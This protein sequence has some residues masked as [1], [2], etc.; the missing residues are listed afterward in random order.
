[1]SGGISVLDSVFGGE[2]EWTES[3]KRQVKRLTDRTA[4]YP[5]SRMDEANSA[6]AMAD[7]DL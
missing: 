4:D 1:M 6:L 2:N 5:L 3:T 7:F